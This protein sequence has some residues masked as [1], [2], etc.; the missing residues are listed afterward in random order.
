VWKGKLEVNVVVYCF[1]MGRLWCLA[2]I[3]FV[4]EV[5]Q[6]GYFVSLSF[7]GRYSSTM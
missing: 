4:F 7:V 5:Y 2:D 6:L 3:V 1:C